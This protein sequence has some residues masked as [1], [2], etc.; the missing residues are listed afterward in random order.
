VSD[1]QHT[2]PHEVLVTLCKYVDCMLLLIIK[3]IPILSTVLRTHSSFSTQVLKHLEVILTTL[4]RYKIEAMTHNGAIDQF[5]HG[6]MRQYGHHVGASG[7]YNQHASY[8]L[9]NLANNILPMFTDR[10]ATGPGQY[11]PEMYSLL[12]PA[13]KLASRLLMEKYPL[14]WFCHLTF[15]ERRSDRSGTYIVSTHY[16]TSADAIARVRHNICA[17]GEQVTFM[18][19]P[20]GYPAD[21]T[22]GIT[23]NS[24]HNWPFS[25]EFRNHWPPSAHHTSRKGYARPLIVL[26][27]EFRAYFLQHVA[28]SSQDEH[29]RVLLLLAITIVHE[30][31][32]AFEFWLTPESNEPRWSKSDK[33]AELGWSWEATCIGY[34]LHHMMILGQPFMRNRYLYQFKVL[35]YNSASERERVLGQFGGSHRTD[36]AFTR[37]DASGCI[38]NPP[39]LDANDLP[40]SNLLFED[41]MNVASFVAA[42]QVVPMSWV[43]NWFLEEEWQRRAEIWC[44]RNMYVRPSLGNAFMLLYERSGNRT[45]TLR[46]LY[47]AF[48]ADKDILDRRARGDYSR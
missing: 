29:Y 42:A 35:E 47:S 15:G 4:Q 21:A 5:L 33:D 43:V 37:A 20:P 1:S 24:K 45:S 8:P 31:V 38:A 9:P 25:K 23:G 44:H 11:T 6:V 10:W 12:K 26:N 39:I 17:V 13:F 16:S 46:P 27:K 41:E 14:L 36:Y 18:F 30:F 3:A 19:H 22:M 28:S 2:W 7:G 34:G 48:P 32:H 40:D